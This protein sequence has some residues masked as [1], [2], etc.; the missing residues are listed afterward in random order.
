MHEFVFSPGELIARQNSQEIPSF[1]IITEGN[2]EIFID[3]NGKKKNITIKQL[4]E[5]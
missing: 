2:L 5:N 3:I 1:N 4:K